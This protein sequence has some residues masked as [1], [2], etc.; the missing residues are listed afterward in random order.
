M[1]TV[2]LL[3]HISGTRNGEDWPPAGGRIDLPDQEAEDMV[4]NGY[5]AYADPVPVAVLEEPEQAV[6]EAPEEG[7]VEAPEAAVVDAPERRGGKA[8]KAR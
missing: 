6:V 1:R 4:R 3:I 2:R 8:A 5:A 7:A